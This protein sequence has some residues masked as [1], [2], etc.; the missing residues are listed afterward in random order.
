M[1]NQ[2][3]LFAIGQLVRHKLFNYRG[4]VV[5]V[6]PIFM[7][8]DEWYEEMAVNRPPKN[9]PWYYILVHNATHQTYVAERNLE[10]DDSAEPIDHPDIEAIFS[11]FSNGRYI[12][13]T[14][15]N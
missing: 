10:M 5:D 8:P 4:V 2:C 1:R 3:A 7:G 15:Q 13:N 12:K 9:E 11:E 6:D 14:R